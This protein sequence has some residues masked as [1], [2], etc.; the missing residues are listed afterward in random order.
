M[1][2]DEGFRIAA[3]ERLRISGFGSR[4]PIA[5]EYGGRRSPGSL[6]FALNREVLFA[7]SFVRD[8]A[9][10][11]RESRNPDVATNPG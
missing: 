1:P 5:D 7:P 4:I 11:I 6:L 8:F 3:G 9:D 2:R 10:F